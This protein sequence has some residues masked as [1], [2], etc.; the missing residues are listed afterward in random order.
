[1]TWNWVALPAGTTHEQLLQAL[2]RRLKALE[3]ALEITSG[4]AI[5]IGT[6]TDA[7]TT[8]SVANIRL[9]ITA[10]TGATTVTTFDDG[11]IG[12]E[13]MIRFG[14]ANTTLAHGSTLQLIGNANFTGATGDMKIFTTDDGTNWYEVPQ[15]NIYA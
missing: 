15:P 12:Q 3:Q 8:P 4:L 10:N 5:G 14:D 2:N 7:D 9:G 13:V 1:M 6:F 11:V